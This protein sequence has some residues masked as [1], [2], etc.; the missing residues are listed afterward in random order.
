MI[1]EHR[2]Y[3]AT[4][5]ALPRL[6]ARFETMT[7]GFF[8]KHGIRPIGFWTTV[9]GTSNHHLTYLLQW[10]SLD[11]RASKW[12][13]LTSDNDFLAAVAASE[14]DGPIVASSSNQILA[15]TRFSPLK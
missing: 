1:Y 12:A 6:L 10:E 2:V 14:R 8:E 9:V 13:A 15:P 7:L 3:E 4:P 5:G 11:E